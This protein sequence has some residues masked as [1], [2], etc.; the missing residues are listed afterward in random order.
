MF[1]AVTVV[2]TINIPFAYFDAGTT[3]IG[4][5]FE[6]RVY[7]EEYYVEINSNKIP[8][9]IF[10]SH[11]SQ[12]VVYILERM[13]LGYDTAYFTFTESLDYMPSWEIDYIVPGIKTVVTTDEGRSFAV[14]LT[15]EKVK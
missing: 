15:T 10:R 8:A 14:T 7:S 9:T 1:I 6:R 13:Q 3:Q 11:N 5:F 4:S 12:G 2:G